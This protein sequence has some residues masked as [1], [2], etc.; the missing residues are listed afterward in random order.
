MP[1]RKDNFKWRY[2][3]TLRGGVGGLWS[4]PYALRC[5]QKWPIILVIT[6]P[7]LPQ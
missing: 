6:N 4:D 7:W 1:A 5:G 2:A 3:N